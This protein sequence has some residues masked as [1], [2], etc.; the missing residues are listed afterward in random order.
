M[1]NNIWF[2]FFLFICL[3]QDYH[4]YRLGKGIGKKKR[5][6]KLFLV[7]EKHFSFMEWKIR[8]AVIVLSFNANLLHRYYVIINFNSISLPGTPL[9]L[10]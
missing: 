9:I 4:I 7:E 6:P 2:L 5:E 10:Q 8:Q 3:Q 1:A